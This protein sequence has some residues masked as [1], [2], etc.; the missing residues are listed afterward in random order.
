[1]NKFGVW[2]FSD[3]RFDEVCMSESNAMGVALYASEEDELGVDN[4]AVIQHDD[5]YDPIWHEMVWCGRFQGY[6]VLFEQCVAFGEIQL[7]TSF[8]VSCLDDENILY[9]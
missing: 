6:K 3:N 8:D 4:Y 1:M 5:A 7:D 2:C 9:L